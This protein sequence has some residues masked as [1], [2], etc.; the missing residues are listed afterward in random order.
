MTAQGGDFN[1][2]PGDVIGQFT[3]LHP[4][5]EGGMGEVWAA[6]Q[7]EPM[8]R[9][10][11]L[12]LL[13]PGLDTR[14]FLARFE[15]ERQALAV[16]DHPNI[17]RVYA[18]DATPG[19]RP[20]YAME[21]VRGVPITTYCDNNRLTTRQRLTLFVAVC[22]AVQHAHQKGVI[23]RD[24]KPS[25][26]LV[27]IVDDAP[28][29]KVIDFGI[30]KAVGAR[31]ADITFA[32]DIR[33]PL[34]TP[35]YMSPEQWEPDQ[36]DIDTRSDIYSLGV[37]LY[38]LLVGRLP[39]DPV[40]L[41]RAGQAVAQLLR[42]VTP[43]MPSTRARSLGADSASLAMAR[44]TDNRALVR[45]LAGDL[46]WITLKAME[47]DRS[48]RYETP[49][50]LA[51]DITRHLNNEPVQARPP[52]VRYRA[53]RFVRRNRLAVAAATMLLVAGSA[54]AVVMA[55]Q[56]RR[57]AV[58]RDRARLEAARARALNDFLQQTLLSPDP[59]QGTGRD[60]TMRQA[61]DSATARLRRDATLLP[62]V[63]ASLES[64]IGW[65][66]FKLQEFDKAEPLLKDALARRYSE[67][68]VDSA[69]LGEHLMRYGAMH[70]ARARLDSAAL[71]YHNGIALLRG[72]GGT[73]RDLAASL[74][75]AAN[76]FR[77]KGDS[78]QARAALDEARRLFERAGDSSGLASVDDMR[79]AVEYEL[80]HLDRA[81]PLFRSALAYRRAHLGQ[82]PLVAN[83]L[84]NLG[85]V[86]EDAKD[87]V[88]A[89]AAYREALSIAER[90]LGSDH[91]IVAATLSNLALLL[92]N[93]ERTAEASRLLQRAL[94]IDERQNGPNHPAVASDLS[95][96]A[97][98]LCRSGKAVEGE[99]AARRALRIFRSGLGTGV[100]QTSAVQGT[101]GRC[102]AAQRRYAEAER[103]MVPALRELTSRLG[104][105]HARVVALRGSLR[106]LYVAWGRPERAD[107]SGR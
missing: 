10:V 72:H 19:G 23:H 49:H 36:F 89:E 35:A 16:M 8:R 86:L 3:L 99:A 70:E 41:M 81:L 28:V 7:G 80:G 76:L 106:E 42:D 74:A 84:A 71:S 27:T 93:T 14:D 40:Q 59:I 78:V 92:G 85:A 30:A 95:V 4:L 54:F 25:N 52:S 46:D 79:G 88:G 13:K 97:P 50:A 2:G 31:I 83:S 53:G 26:V 58:E 55:V 32:T 96:L 105:Q 18:A 20:Y 63:A 68:P 12:K 101:L 64:A 62:S 9:Q 43:A 21:F 45:A 57:L 47:A 39:T 60:V 100:W 107:S 67:R 24:L 15:V 87:T 61:L 5:G 33:Q 73:S 48:R 104:A 11:A 90:T 44:G 77:T 17:A 38:E 69:A 66:Y 94:A 34:G 65:A 22:R 51:Q 6:E 29:P 56:A 91:E 37:M 75:R 98:M 103:E 82:H 102:L 1:L